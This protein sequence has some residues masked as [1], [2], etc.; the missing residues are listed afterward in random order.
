MEE[1]RLILNNNTNYNP[2]CAK[3]Y[4]KNGGYEA[5]KKAVQMTP[6][7]IINT[8]KES[9]LRGR[10]GAGFPMGL[11]ISFVYKT[12]SDQKYVVCNAD[13]GEPGTNKDRV[14]FETVPHSV[15]EGMIISGLACGADKGIIYLRWEYPQVNEL[16]TKALESARKNG[17][18]GKNI[19]G[20]NHNF[21]I[22]IYIG[23]GAYVCGEETALLESIEGKRGEARFKPP[24]PGV[25]G[26]WGK[27]TLINNVETLANVP[28]ILTN[29]PAWFKKFGTEKCPGTKLF[30][31]CGNVNKPGVYEFPMGVNLKDLFAFGGEVK[32][33]KLQAVQLGGVSGSIIN[34]EQLDVK[35]DPETLASK[36]LTLGSGAV[37]F[38]DDSEDMI[39][40]LENIMEFFVHESCGKCTPCREGNMR[41]LELIRKFK[42]HSA[43]LEDIDT[44][45]DLSETMICA[46]L[47]GLGQASPTAIV[48]TIRNMKKV[49]TDR[50][51]E[52]QN[53]G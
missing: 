32:K 1:T 27:P 26:L 50:I 18:L 20:S 39:D 42:D 21:D 28:L 41:L 45:M 4:A 48:T 51:K 25:V 3:E 2:V 17:Y 52:E 49:F 15:I 53:N 24:F 23:A 14:I 36:G 8:L 44:M 47:C 19:L 37:L 38:I 30:T 29:G 31:L 43:T 35:M 13:E 46:S 33:G 7:D 16:L 11:K 6:E 40:L 9:G 12:P 22:E 5:L 10:G 34:A